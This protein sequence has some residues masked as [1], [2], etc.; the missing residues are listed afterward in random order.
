MNQKSD[1]ETHVLDFERPIVDLEE[2]IAELVRFSDK[3]QGVDLSDQIREMRLRLDDM[4]RE[5][6]AGLTP[7]QRVQVARHPKRP[8]FTDYRNAFIDSWLELHGDRAFRNDRS[9]CT[10]FGRIGGRKVLVVA[11]RKGRTTKERVA[12]N[13][14]M[15]HPEGYRKALR[16]MKLAEKILVPVVTFIDT[17]GAYPGV[18]A[19]ERG[20]S[21]AIAENLLEMARLRVPVVCVILAEGGSGGALGIGVGDR[22]LMLENAYYSVI[23]PEG[24]SAILWKTA[25]RAADAANILKITADDLKRFGVVD[26]I[27]PEPA[28]GA[29]RDARAAAGLLRASVEKA[30]DEVCAHPLPELLTE[31]YAKLR[32]IGAWI[33][34]TEAI[35]PSDRIDPTDPTDPTG[36]MAEPA[37]TGDAEARAG[38]GAVSA[39]T[40]SS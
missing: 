23:S 27:I 32:S 15:P 31:R 2:K 11:H 20:Q 6:F 24:C 36:P 40:Q 13:F 39:A 10:G 33:E 12:C 9:I 38:G 7:W 14:G 16:K 28:G 1:L 29:H 22:V 8:G 34:S 26:E 3:A 18:G 30:L 37:P 25:D 21:H 19:E 5:I 17:A 4:V 35:E